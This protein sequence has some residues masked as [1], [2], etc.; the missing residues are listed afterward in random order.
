MWSSS[1]AFDAFYLE[2]SINDGE[3]YIIVYSWALQSDAMNQFVENEKCYEDA[4]V[5]DSKQIY[6]FDFFTDETKVRFRSSANGSNDSVYIDEV[7]FEGTDADSC[8]MRSRSGYE[9]D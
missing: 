7:K 8:D 5:L 1:E 3:E 6:G 9:E 4:I 2:I